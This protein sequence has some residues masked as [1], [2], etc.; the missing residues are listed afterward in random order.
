V[1]TATGNP[2]AQPVRQTSASLDDLFPSSPSLKEEIMFPTKKTITV[3]MALAL[4][5]AVLVAGS[6]AAE[7]T[8]AAPPFQDAAPQSAAIPYAGQ[9]NNAA[10]Q[11]V[12]DGKYDFTFSLYDAPTG[13]DLLWTGTQADVN[14]Q[15]GSFSASLG[16]DAGLPQAVLDRKEVWLAVGVRGPGET[17]FT[18]LEPRQL[19]PTDGPAAV[20]ALSCPHSH[21]TDSW[22]G[23]NP[24]W[25]LYLSNASTGDGLRAYSKATAWNY[26]AVFGANTATTGYGTGVYGYSVKGLGMRAE[27]KGSDGL[28]AVTSISNKS[29]VYAHSANGYGVT[30]RSISNFGVQAG[31]GGDSSGTDLMGDLFLEGSRGEMFTWGDRLYLYSN[32]WISFFLD[33]NNNGFNSLEVYNG[34]N[35]L[36]FK[37]DESGNT[38]ATGTK[39]AEVQTANYGQRLMYTIESPEVWFEDVGTGQLVAGAATVLFDP[40]FAETAN[41]ETDYH[42]FVTPNCKEAAVLFVTDKMATGFTVQGVTM[43]NEPSSCAFDY[44]V[45]A[46]R[47]GY[48]GARL[49][50]VEPNAD[51]QSSR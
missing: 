6:G 20:S 2:A 4:V 46:K 40:I 7:T 14:V 9:L 22:S 27:S 17:A 10:G 28:E 1:I 25:G 26:A 5:M 19:L 36:V 49:T 12:A 15:G 34:A 32:G 51:S 37:V 43:S 47:L 35:N 33:N 8:H 39:S 11:P 38:V 30:G 29:A 48:E 3:I 23:S 16:S 42:V 41:L 31:G 44:R 24:N 13:G 50:P 45:A 18:A 21:F